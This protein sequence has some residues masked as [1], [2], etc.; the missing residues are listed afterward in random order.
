MDLTIREEK[1][2]DT[3]QRKANWF[4]IIII[5][6]IAFVFAGGL[7]WYSK[8]LDQIVDSI[9]TSGSLTTKNHD[10]ACLK[11]GGAIAMSSCCLAASDFPNS[12]NIGACGCAA[13]NS[14][15]IKT[16]DCGE[17]KCWNGKKC[18]SVGGESASSLTRDFSYPYPVF[19]NENSADISLTG[20]SL[21][22]LTVPKFA[23]K[24]ADGNFYAAGEKAYALTLHFEI[25]TGTTAP[26]CV[27]MSLRMQ[28]SDT[29][30]LVA[31][32]TEQFVFPGSNGCQ[33]K[34]NM[35]YENQRVVFVVPEGQKSFTI[36][37]GG[38][39]NI[40]FTVRA[41]GNQLEVERLGSSVNE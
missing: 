37:T 11:S 14:H 21:G 7:Y 29:G 16:C 33:P 36:T 6:V 10:D 1:P 41:D 18:I 28:R 27:P 9:G 5:V 40:L 39:S 25:K 20:L 3:T 35:T 17:S 31:P 22:T 13:E 19:W 8:G 24:K 12:C 32:N 34:E 15:R 2:K 23:L 30:G 38:R 26:D 4:F